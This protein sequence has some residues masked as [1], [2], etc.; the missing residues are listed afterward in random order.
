M[1]V[2][3]KKVAIALVLALLFSQIGT[4]VP[5]SAALVPSLK[6]SSKVLYI[7]GDATGKYTDNCWIPSQN[8][9]DYKV[10]YQV[11]SNEHLITVSKSGKITAT[12][13]G[14]GAAV[15][16]V[17]YS[18]TSEKDITYK[19]TAK[20]RRN[21]TD[22]KLS[23]A[24]VTKLD[25][26]LNIGDRITLQA[27][28]SY[29]GSYAKGHY[30]FDNFRGV[31]NDTLEI[32]S[33]TPAIVTA[34]GLT[35]TAVS[36]GTAKFVVKAYQFGEN[37]YTGVKSIEYSIVVGEPVP[38]VTEVPEVEIKQISLTKITLKTKQTFTTAPDINEISIAQ[39]DINGTIDIQSVSI[40]SADKT[41]LVIETYSDM[42]D[43][44]VF[45]VA[46]NNIEGTFTA[47]DGV[48]ANLV[49]T[50]L[51][52]EALV[53]TKVYVQ[54]IDS[55]GIILGQYTTADA[56]GMNELEFADALSD[57]GYMDTSDGKLTLYNVGSTATVT[58]TYHTYKYD[59]SG[60]EIGA[61]KRTATI[62]GIKP[63]PVTASDYKYTIAKTVPDYSSLTTNIAISAMD[64][65]NNFYFYLSDSNG[66]DVSS[67]YTLSSS[68]PDAIIVGDEMIIDAK[69]I[70][71]SIIAVSNKYKSAQVIVKKGDTVVATVMVNIRAERALAA[72]NIDKTSAT[73]SNSS[74]L[75]TADSVIVNVS[76]IDQYSEKMSMDD[77]E[78][79]VTCLSAPT[80]VLRD[81]ANG[82]IESFAVQTGT[83]E[84]TFYAPS[85]STRGTYT[86]RITVGTLSKVVT[87]NI[88][89]PGTGTSIYKL[90]LST[91]AVDQIV[92]SSNPKSKEI[93]VRIGE[94]INN[95]LYQYVSISGAALKVAHSDGTTLATQS[96][97]GYTWT[98]SILDVNKSPV[99][100]VK[101]GKYTVTAT[102]SGRNYTGSF[103]V[104]DTQSGVTVGQVVKS[105]QS[106]SQG[107]WSDI[108]TEA[109]DFVY[110]GI[111]VDASVASL[112]YTGK[113][114]GSNVLAS[115]YIEPGSYNITSVTLNVLV[116]DYLYVPITVSVGKTVTIK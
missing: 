97:D 95:V 19:F 54:Y 58:A 67:E 1:K 110:E 30:G 84:I 24:S 55:T 64:E 77:Q 60:N 39:K 26:A 48:V 31:V 80:T 86:F 71:A 51:R 47:T 87:I 61:I 43:K 112:S 11:T 106:I 18:K 36:A 103:T 91:N 25:T 102:V 12:G 10:K 38:E 69:G 5:V 23:A 6:Y 89:T 29:D 57:D 92:P 68:N 34:K 59:T 50:P 76:A 17:T 32:E 63:L 81:E 4:I 93:N 20:I 21:A 115:T 3:F 16:T 35:L 41:K 72:I 98:I 94:Y 90:V 37:T 82:Y 22:V 7:D 44:N 114:K 83:G 40:D 111:N 42:K 49:F 88:V 113:S 74:A 100:K 108:L 65:G 66:D 53:P 101:N 52:V 70:H 13:N 14:V 46:Y 33:L 85:F 45:K 79:V 109:F 15:V 107:Y 75:Q 2:I 9:G 28:K 99:T 116:A 62:T 96:V 8:K 105:G 104:T 78:I 73:L 27:A 56:L